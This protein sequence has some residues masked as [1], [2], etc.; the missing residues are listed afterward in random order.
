[1]AL[2]RIIG[3]YLGSVF[4]CNLPGSIRM[5]GLAFDADN[6][7]HATNPRGTMRTINRIVMD[8]N[9][10]CG[11]VKLGSRPCNTKDSNVIVDHVTGCEF[12]TLITG[13][14]FTAHN[15]YQEVIAQW[16]FYQPDNPYWK[17]A[18]T[19]QR[20]CGIFGQLVIMGD[21]WKTVRIY[22]YNGKFVC[23]FE[24]QWPTHAKLHGGVRCVAI[25]SQGDICVLNGQYRPI[26]VFNRRGVFLRCIGSTEMSTTKGV[27]CDRFDRVYIHG[28]SFDHQP[29]VCVYKLDGTLLTMFGTNDEVYDW[30]VDQYNR[31]LITFTRHDAQLMDLCI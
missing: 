9:G 28:Q 16:S 13:T 2:I 3:A 8:D 10:Q 22:E 24:L 25:S 7:L 15:N 23:A 26:F 14:T 19:Y 12:T 1:L 18:Q 17:P 4:I 11:I 5:F 31:L 27:I 30:C 20:A 29:H 6:E 21:D